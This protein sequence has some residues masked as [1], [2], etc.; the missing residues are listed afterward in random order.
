MCRQQQDFGEAQQATHSRWQ[1][2]RGQVAFPHI[3]LYLRITTSL[4]YLTAGNVKHYVRK[5]TRCKDSQIFLA[6][7]YSN[8]D[9]T[10][11]GQRVVGLRKNQGL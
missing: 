9:S 7:W 2:G 11:S 3:N 6:V 5:L 4:V 8:R 1:R 10:S